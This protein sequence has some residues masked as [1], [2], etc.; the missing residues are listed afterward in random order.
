MRWSLS[1][2]GTFEKCPARYNYKYILK[3]PEPTRHAAATRGIELHKAVEDFVSGKV[4]KLPSEIDFYTQFLSGL[5]QHENYPEHKVALT[6]EWTPTEWDGEDTWYR[7]VLDLK[8]LTGPKPEGDPGATSGCGTEPTEAVVYDWKSGK[9]Y[10]DHDDQKSLYSLST[11]SE[12]PSV[13]R[14]RA[15]H[16]YLDLGQNREITY[17]RDQMHQLRELWTARVGHLERSIQIGAFMPNPSYGC[18]YCP[19]SRSVGGPCRF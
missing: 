15:I 18:R 14:V 11:F 6:R 1:A 3:I 8:L 13:R 9:I 17:D 4:E 2:L 10:P 16:V 12:H 19:F 5:R 7:G